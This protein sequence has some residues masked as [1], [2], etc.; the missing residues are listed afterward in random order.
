MSEFRLYDGKNCPCPS[1]C[2]RRGD[3]ASCMAFHHER[4]QLTY[5]EFLKEKLERGGIP[6][7]SLPTGK[8]IR[9]TDYGPCAG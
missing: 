7:R 6:E 2:K 5:C 9:L 4:H 3:C 8:Q 1:D